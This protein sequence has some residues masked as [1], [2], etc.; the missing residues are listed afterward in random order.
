MPVMES[1]VVNDHGEA[2]WDGK[3]MGELH[4]RGAWVAGSYFRAPE[5]ADC[6]SD[7]GW[8]R[9][10]GVGTIDGEGYVQI[11]DR[12]KDLIKS[13]G[14]WISSVDLENALAAHPAVREAGV[15]A[16][17]HPKWDERPVAIVVLRPGMTTTA[18]ELREFLSSRFAKWQLPDAFAFSDE[19][20]PPSTRKLSKLH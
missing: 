4:V 15:I 13:G 5:T 6:W 19:W 3:A 14:E 9:T 18:D 12:A 11:A 7:D 8:V 20:P 17:P 16:V 2:P 10:G 1:R